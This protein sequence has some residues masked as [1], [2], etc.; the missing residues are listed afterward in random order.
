MPKSPCRGCGTKKRH[1]GNCPVK[2]AEKVEAVILEPFRSFGKCEACGRWCWR[3][4]PA[5]IFSRGAGK[6]TISENLVALCRECHQG[7]H[8]GQWPYRD[9]LLK[10]A[11]AREKTTP[12]AIRDL[13]HRLRR[14]RTQN[15]V[16]GQ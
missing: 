14:E 6:V 4:D 9:D 13:V 10:I 11:A 5:H 12:E 15:L 8:A 7:N 2:A 1:K 3:R 16:R